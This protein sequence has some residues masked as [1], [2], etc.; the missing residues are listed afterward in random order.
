[1]FAQLPLW[2]DCVFCVLIS[3]CAK[4]YLWDDLEDSIIDVVFKTETFVSSTGINF[5]YWSM[6]KF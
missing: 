4:Q 3:V 5:K 1:V 6:R 2:F